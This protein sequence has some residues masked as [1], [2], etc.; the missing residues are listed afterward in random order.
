MLTILIVDVETSG[1]PSSRNANY[2]DLDKY[3]NAR[4][5]QISYMI[6]DAATLETISIVDNV[7][8]ADGFNITNSQFH[9]VT[10]EISQEQGIPFEDAANELAGYL[11]DVTHILAHNA[12]FDINIIKSELFRRPELQHIIEELNKKSVVCTMKSTMAM[13]KA[14]NKYGIK[15]PSLAELY[16]HVFKGQTLENAHNA[17]YDVIYLHKAIKQ[18]FQDGKFRF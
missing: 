13:V 18:L 16:S 8:K 12:D 4:I 6:C 7:I 17:K 5:V 3:K 15:F 10:D 1:L 14:R 2:K 11:P 9:W